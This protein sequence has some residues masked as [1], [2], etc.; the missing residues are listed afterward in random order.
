M[1]TASS[2]HY[3]GSKRLLEEEYFPD[4]ISEPFLEHAERFPPQLH[5][6]LEVIPA[7]ITF[8]LPHFLRRNRQ[9]SINGIIEMRFRWMIKDRMMIRF[10]TFSNFNRKLSKTVG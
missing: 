1:E 5:L 10:R 8:S 7:E 4:P 9:R 2:G 3:E 6:L